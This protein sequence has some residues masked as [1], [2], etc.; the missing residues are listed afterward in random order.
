MVLDIA[1][2]STENSAN[3]Q[4]WSYQNVLQQKFRVEYLNN[5]YYT[6]KCIKS[7]KVLDVANGIATNGNNVWQYESNGTEAQQ[8][9]IKDC[10]DGYYNIVSACNDMFLDVYGG[11]TSC[12]TNIQIYEGNNTNAQK[13][14]FEPVTAI[15][16]EEGTYG[17]SGLKVK[18]D[19]RGQSLKY[20]KI[21]SLNVKGSIL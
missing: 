19:G 10:G 20:Y 1:G 8:W 14:K 12:G 21:G 2:A 4:I 13:F 3:V 11:Y 17:S 9:I 15:E 16:L 18:G 7:N 6:I 5:G